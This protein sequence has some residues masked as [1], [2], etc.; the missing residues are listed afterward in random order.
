MIRC[1]VYSTANGS[2]EG[3]YFTDDLEMDA[4]DCIPFDCTLS[5]DF[6]IDE[7][8]PAGFPLNYNLERAF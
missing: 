2:K 8:F 1:I 6:K 3:V 5:E 7:D 4:T